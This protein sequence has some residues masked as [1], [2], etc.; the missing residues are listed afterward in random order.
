[1]SFKDPQ[2]LGRGLS[3]WAP[4]QG[5]VLKWS[6]DPSPTHA[7]LILNPGSTPDYVFAYMTLQYKLSLQI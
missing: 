2:S 3:P 7:P 6:P 4:Y 5:S 1:L